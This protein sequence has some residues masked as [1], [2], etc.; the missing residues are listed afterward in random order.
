MEYGINYEL[1]GCVNHAEQDLY[2]KIN[3]KK[4]QKKYKINIKKCNNLIM[5]SIRLRIKDGVLQSSKCCIGCINNT[6]KCIIKGLNIKTVEWVDNDNIYQK[7]KL[8]DLLKTIYGNRKSN[9]I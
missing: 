7:L 5:K 4:N 3:T 6:Y 8:D 1:N 2:K 9:F